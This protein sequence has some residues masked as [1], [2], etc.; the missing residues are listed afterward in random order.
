VF[1][2]ALHKQRVD[3]QVGLVKEAGLIPAAAYSKAAA[4][5]LA[6][7]VPDAILIHL[8]PS[9]AAI[10][11]SHQGELQVVHQLELGKGD[12]TPETRARALARAAGQVA[13][14][15]QPFD[16]LEQGESLPIV[17]TGQRS[18]IDQVVNALQDIL[19][20][21]ALPPRLPLS[22]PQDFPLAEYATN[23]G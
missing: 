11:L 10:V 19:H 1:A 21:P 7:G 14:Y 16:N 17:L 15:Y 4:L 12:A 6:A 22:Y 20:R 3:S 13:G 9:E 5:A 23:V 2:I 18:E 8:E